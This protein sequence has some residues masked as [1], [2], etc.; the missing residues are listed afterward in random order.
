MWRRVAPADFAE[1]YAVMQGSQRWLLWSVCN[2]Y[3]IQRD[4]IVAKY[5]FNNLTEEW[6]DYLPF[7]DAPGLFLT[8][9]RLYKENNLREAALIFGR[10]YGLPYSTPNIINGDVIDHDPAIRMS[11]SDFQKE[12]A[13]AY[14]VLSMYEAVLNRDSAAIRKIFLEHR[15]EVKRLDLCYQFFRMGEM[16]DDEPL[17]PQIGFLYTVDEV[18]KT[19]HET[20]RQRIRLSSIHG[21]LDLSTVE[22]AWQFDSL[23]GAMYLQMWWLIASGESIARCEFCGRPVSLARSHPGARKRRRDKKFCG[24]ACRQ[25][26]HRSKKKRQDTEQD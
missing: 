17:L 18:E 26:H 5:E 13:R 20:C 10:Q 22:T 12:V 15:T 24:D 19:V 2:E 21:N 16:H 9:S 4:E 25:G 8:F 14:C 6:W 7:E 11:I 1:S 3:E 23:L